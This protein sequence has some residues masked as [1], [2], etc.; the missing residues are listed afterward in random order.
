MPGKTQENHEGMKQEWVDLVD[1]KLQGSLTEAD[2]LKWD[3]YSRDPDF[4]ELQKD[5]ATFPETFQW[6][7]RME[8]KAF[9]KGLSN[10]TKS[11]RKPWWGVGIFFVLLGLTIWLISQYERTES[12]TTS[13]PIAA[14]YPPPPNTVYPRMRGKKSID[15][16]QQA[17]Q[18]YDAKEFDRA[19]AL[20]QEEGSIETSMELR[21]Y[22]GVS[23]LYANRPDAAVEMLSPISQSNHTRNNSS[24]FY[25]S[26]GYLDLQNNNKAI[27]LLQSLREKESPYQNRADS[28][29][30]RIKSQK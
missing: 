5:L 3:K 6:A 13:E 4:L 21:F 8:R 2:Q 1:K 7:E 22:A 18:Y 12:P 27:A 25:L 10:K 9:L 19:Y 30:Q 26:K 24:T 16:I 23:A 20:F 17:F 11:N 28:V 14:L 15:E 29:L